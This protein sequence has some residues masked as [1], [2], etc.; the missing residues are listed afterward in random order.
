M[1]TQKQAIFTKDAVGGKITVVKEFNAPVSQV[2][3]AWTEAALLDQWWAPKP[4]K[5]RTK[6]MDFR[7]GGL[8]HYAMVGPDGSEQWCRVDFITIVPEQRFTV[9]NGFAD[10]E[11]NRT[12]DLPDMNWSNDFVATDNGTKVTIQIN[13]ESEVEMKKI[14]ELGFEEGFQ[15]GL[16]NLDELLVH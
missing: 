8:W 9:I 6:T 16:S 3:K 1:T 11:G 7:E 15:A 4:W 2:W 5:A 14:I 12:H 10:A 13:F